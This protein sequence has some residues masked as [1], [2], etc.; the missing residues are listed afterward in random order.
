MQITKLVIENFRS[1]VGRNEID[2]SVK[3]GKPLVLILGG[4]GYGKTSILQAVQWCF[5]GYSYFGDTIEGIVSHMNESAR[6]RREDMHVQLTIKHEKQTWN[7]SR[8]LCLMQ[9][10][11]PSEP[12]S[13]FEDPPE[14]EIDGALQN[15][16]MAI[17]SVIP[18]NAS[19]FFFF[20]AEQIDIYTR[21][22]H[23]RPVREAIEL[24]LNLPM[25]TNAT[26]DLKDAIT[27]LEKQKVKMARKRKK[28]KAQ[29]EV[30]DGTITEIE[31]LRKRFDVDKIKLDKLR[32]EADDKEKV[33]RRYGDMQKLIDQLN[34][35]SVAIEKQNSEVIKAKND[36]QNAVR[37]APLVL[38]MKQLKDSV[39]YFNSKASGANPSGKKTET[40]VARVTVLDS[41]VGD[42]ECI[43]LRPIDDDVRAVLESEIERIRADVNGELGTQVPAE[44]YL[45][46]EYGNTLLEEA[47]SVTKSVI[48]A[49][50]TLVSEKSKLTTLED[51]RKKIQAK[52]GDR[53]TEEY[54]AIADR[55]ATLARDII[56]SLE[57]AHKQDKESLQ[58]KE[59][60]KEGLS[61][62]IGRIAGF[63][64]S[65]ELE[66]KENRA[67]RA[68]RAIRA[69]ENYFIDYMRERVEKEA[70]ATFKSM[71]NM[72]RVFKGVVVGEGF[73]LDLLDRND[74]SFRGHKSSTGQKEVLALAF[75]AGLAKASES[76]SP[77]IMDSALQRFDSIHKRNILR[78]M[79]KLSEQVILLV[80]PDEEL[81]KKDIESIRSYVSREIRLEFDQETRST[82]LEEC[83]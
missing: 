32:K 3:P 72:P 20:D 25:I 14:V 48:E 83:S 46:I 9:D 71:T 70:T 61:R 66:L 69:K 24:V 13:Y 63:E 21:A 74:K 10:G 37:R 43:C 36:L 79:T 19:Q 34:E 1:Y 47:K 29:A 45:F 57:E 52:I 12:L 26:E 18:R 27:Q 5:Y 58:A 81:S 77:F 2:L 65:E 11:N 60:Y 78:T 64:E 76:D 68:L 22:S 39:Q 35:K 31:R 55:F 62:K 33:L 82:T 38:L 51:D 23:S 6:L 54:S 17:E 30:L 15:S 53:D 40:N 42:P 73:Q 44:T 16:L 75:M 28:T 4:N 7:I 49:M 59:T 56:P 67:R 41:I 50:T 80:L 8:S